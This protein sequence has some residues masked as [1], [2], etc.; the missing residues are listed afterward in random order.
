MSKNCLFGVC[1]PAPT[2]GGVGY[3]RFA[4]CVTGTPKINFCLKKSAPMILK[5]T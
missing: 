1:A 3:R 5:F 2:S 4:E